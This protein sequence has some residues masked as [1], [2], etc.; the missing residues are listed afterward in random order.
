M[1]NLTT[2][3]TKTRV[4]DKEEFLEAFSY[5]NR[6]NP[7]KG[8]QHLDEIK[9]IL[10]SSADAYDLLRRLDSIEDEDIQSDCRRAALAQLY[11]VKVDSWY[12]GGKYS[13][14]YISYCKNKIAVI[15]LEGIIGSVVLS[16]Y[17]HIL[18]DENDCYING[19][20]F[21]GPYAV[22]R[23][24]G[25]Y[26]VYSNAGEFVIP[27][28]IFDSIN[29]S[30]CFPV[31]SHKFL[32]LAFTI[33]GNLASIESDDLIQWDN[34]WDDDDIYLIS[35]DNMVSSFRINYE[36]YEEMES[37]RRILDAPDGPEFL[38]NIAPYRLTKARIQ[39]ELDRRK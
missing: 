33:Y 29:L 20:C 4:I 27:F 34:T 36:E 7:G 2:M 35:Q 25:T 13:Q 26:G 37:I 16:K 11:G 5:L 24:N 21:Y 18:A 30:D 6:R 12:S 8:K 31:A 3:D 15:S 39:Q 9:G 17:G 28:G 1:H 38:E 19:H 14:N 10:D 22:I 32:Y 23:K